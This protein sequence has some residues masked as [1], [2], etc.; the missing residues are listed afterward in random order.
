MASSEV[1]SYSPT[2]SHSAQHLVL[3]REAAGHR[4]AVAVD[5]GRWSGVVEKPSP[6]AASDCRR[7][8]ADAARAR[9]A[10]TPARSPRPARSGAARSG[11]TMNPAFTASAPSSPSRYSPKRLPLP[12]HALLEGHE[13]HALDLGHHPAGVVGVGLLQRRQREA[14]VA[15]DD[16]GDAVPA[17]RRGQRVPVELGVVVGV[18]VDEAGRDDQVGG[19]DRRAPPARSTVPTATMRPSLMPTS[20]RRPGAARAVDDRPAG[21]RVIEHGRPL[22]LGT[23]STDDT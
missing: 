18:G 19:V 15:A 17:R 14:A 2:T 23:T 4:V 22:C 20:A 8:T 13:G 6:P 21:D 9:R 5:V 3:G 1:P 10:W 16:A 12:R 7:S 11:P